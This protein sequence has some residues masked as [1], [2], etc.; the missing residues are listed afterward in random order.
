MGSDKKTADI[1]ENG[2]KNHGDATATEGYRK[3][4]FH[5]DKMMLEFQ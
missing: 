3:E 4:V 2:K 5:E 1:E